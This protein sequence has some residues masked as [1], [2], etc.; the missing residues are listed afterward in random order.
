MHFLVILLIILGVILTAVIIF[1]IK[2]ISTP[3]IVS[4]LAAL[5]KQGKIAQGTKLAKHIISKEPRNCEAHYQLALCYLKDHK[6]E[7]A[8]M[9]FQT[10]NQIGHFGTYCPEIEFR[11]RIAELYVRFEHI[12]EA[13]K[14]YLLLVKL[15]PE[16][17][18]HYLNI[19]KLFEEWNKSEKAANFYRKAVELDPRSSEGHYH[20]GLL[21]YKTKKP[22][23]AKMELELALK[24]EPE[25]LQAQFYLGRL[26]KD[27]HDYV[28][29]LLSFE[30]AQRSSE[31][32][33]KALI[34]RGGCYMSMN[35]YDKAISE[36]TRAVKLGTDP[37]AI[38]TIYARYFLAICH[39][40]MRNIDEAIEQWE[41]IYSKKPNFRDV[42]EKLSQYQDLKTDDKI[43]DYLTSSK[44]AFIGICKELTKKLNLSVRDA[45]EIANGCQI[46]AVEKDSDKWRNTRK[47]PRLIRFL[48]IP[49]LIPES[50]VRAMHEEMKK[51]G[52]TRGIIVSSTNFSR[53]AIEYTESRP[54]D[55]INSDKLQNLL[56]NIKLTKKSKNDKNSMYS[57][58]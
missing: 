3:K 24:I 19:G 44:D 43:K 52:V 25:N 32:K 28:G 17:S 46:L 27:S 49:E 11:K 9:E 1:I 6:P 36:L 12:E 42:A 8:L 13:L 54:I 10:V 53:K 37:S 29:A 51:I 31:L 50:T 22:V 15:E 16:I 48:R 58:S 2:S 35:N 40:K 4:S 39:E 55:L 7:I 26:R 47:M 20:L 21:L 23:E 56:Q 18:G 57:R 41:K 14:E 5:V 30:K 38:E 33:V 45:G 34:E